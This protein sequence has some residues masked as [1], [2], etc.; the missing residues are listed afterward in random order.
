MILEFWKNLTTTPKIKQAKEMGYVKEAIA[1]DARAKRCQQ[2]WNEHYQNC[3]KVIL[4]AAERAVQHRTVL[5]FGAGSLKDVPVTELATQFEQVYLV[6]L[7]FLKSAQNKVQGLENVFLIE[8]DVTESLDWIS[9][10]EAVVQSPSAWLD[11]TTIDLVVSLNLITQ[12]PLIPVRWLITDFNLSE[13]DADI[14][15]KQLIFAHMY[16]L[17]QFSGE[18]CLIA[19]RLDI[20]FNELGQ[21]IDR[22]D[23]WWDVEPPKADFNWEWQVIPLGENGSNKWQKN[24]VGV[25]FL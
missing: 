2:E 19:D 11:D 25:S 14:V 7:V 15:G 6:D 18:V 4:K 20:E 16:Y 17:R 5:I 1:M 22:F 21:E 9:Q 3:Q 10:G 13:E 8:H 24:Y 12:L 23:P